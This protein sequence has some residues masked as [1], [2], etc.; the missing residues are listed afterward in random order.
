[1]HVN[2]TLILCGAIMGFDYAR[3][4]VIGRCLNFA[5]WTNGSSHAIYTIPPAIGLTLLYRPLITKLDVYKIV[6]LITVCR[7]FV[8]AIAGQR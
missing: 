7:H 4:Y 8:V 3:V 1:V 5:C 2:C 6:F